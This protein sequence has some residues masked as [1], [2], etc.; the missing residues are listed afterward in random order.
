MLKT[1]PIA[2]CLLWLIV[3]EQ[4]LDRLL[5]SYAYYGEMVWWGFVAL[6]TVLWWTSE[7]KVLRE[8][9]RNNQRG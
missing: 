3:I 1:D 4:G 7:W 2:K 5:E 9:R 8:M 6:I